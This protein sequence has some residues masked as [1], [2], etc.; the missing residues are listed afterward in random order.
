MNC[1]IIDPTGSECHLRPPKRSNFVSLEIQSAAQEDSNKKLVRESLA[2]LLAGH[3]VS[4][5]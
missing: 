5:F 2:R 1:C 4:R 3:R